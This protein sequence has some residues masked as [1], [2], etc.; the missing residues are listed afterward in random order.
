MSIREQLEKMFVPYRFDEGTH[1]GLGDIRLTVAEQEKLA[2]DI[3]KYI[4]E[5][6][7]DTRGFTCGVKEWEE[8]L[9]EGYY[10]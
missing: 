6:K 3:E 10:G 7:P 9:K 4:I 1:E 2:L 8:N 5:C